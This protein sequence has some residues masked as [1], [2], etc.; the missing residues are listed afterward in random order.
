MKIATR[1]NAWFPSI[2]EDLLTE[3]RLDVSNYENFSIPKV[4]IKENL[5]N[6]IVELAAPGFN[7]ENFSIEVDDTT[8]KISGKVA[9]NDK[10][11]AT[12]KNES[13]TRRE[14]RSNSFERSF[15]ISDSIEIE[16]LSA[17]YE[18]GIL[19]ITLPKKEE[20][21]AVKKMVEIS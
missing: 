11:E 6:F 19:V 14:F 18:N 1:N 12:N 17:A 2:L 10:K 5:A 15:T 16:N 20:V 9:S 4:N 7:K 21:K 13:Y 8:L 3:N